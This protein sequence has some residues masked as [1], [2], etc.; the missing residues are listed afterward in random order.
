MKL[1][2]TFK[3]ALPLLLERRDAFYHDARSCEAMAALMQMAD[4]ADE[5]ACERARQLMNCGVPYDDAVTG[6]SVNIGG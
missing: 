1:N 5:C 6:M 3:D 4:M 2:M